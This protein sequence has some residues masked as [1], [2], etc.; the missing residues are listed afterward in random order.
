MYK[1]NENCFFHQQ[2]SLILNYLEIVG[3]FLKIKFWW[4][5]WDFGSDRP[6]DFILHSVRSWET[7][8]SSVSCKMGTV[9][10]LKGW[11]GDQTR[12]SH[13]ANAFN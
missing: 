7:H 3:N 4:E 13:G 6:A 12:K 11:G 8:E 2:V 5:S 1:C 9:T 10:P